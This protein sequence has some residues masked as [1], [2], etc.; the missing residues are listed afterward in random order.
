MNK[1]LIFK[2][3]VMGLIIMAVL[4]ACQSQITEEAESTAV[5]TPPPTSA[6]PTNTPEQTA[7]PAAEPT[8]TPA[9]AILRT[10]AIAAEQ[11]EVRFFI[12]ELLFGEP[13]T[14]VGRTNQITG[15]IQLDLNRP[16]AVELDPIEINA[17]DLTTDSSFRNRALRSQILDSAE[18]AYQFITFT[19]TEIDGLTGETAVIGQPVSFNL[20]GDL[21]IRDISNT[22]TF[23]MS[24]TAVSETELTG[25]GVVT[26]LRSDYDLNIPSVTGVA[27]VADEVRL[28][29]DFIAVATEE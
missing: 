20:I 7:I 12:D 1:R 22:V 21:Q 29:I 5:P 24:A 19:P 15:T 8:V 3:G 25:F 11:S 18:D 13:K 28:E 2:V 10:F 23:V 16:D 17:R 9:P 27:D 4:F 26:V 14:V 6:A